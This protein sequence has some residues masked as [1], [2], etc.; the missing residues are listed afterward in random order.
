MNRRFDVYLLG[1]LLL[2]S[3]GFL[4]LPL[5]AAAVLDESLL[6]WIGSIAVAGSSGMTGSLPQPIRIPTAAHK[7]NKSANLN[8]IISPS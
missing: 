8:F 7:H 1:W 6:A 2:L 4:C 3:S 5:V